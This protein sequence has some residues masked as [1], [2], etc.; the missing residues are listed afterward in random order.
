MASFVLVHGGL[1]GAWCWEPLT[2]ALRERGHAVHAMDLPCDDTTADLNDYVQA[3]LRAMAPLATPP[4]LV[5][6]SM[7]GLIIPHVARQAPVAALVYLCSMVAPSSPAD[8]AANLDLMSEEMKAGRR[9]DPLGRSIYDPAV[10]KSLFFNAV[11]PALQDWAVGRLRPQSQQAWR[12]PPYID[13]LPVAPAFAFVAEDDHTTH[14]P[15]AQR[16]MLRDRLGVEPIVLPGGHSPF[17][18]CPR[19]LADHFD[20]IAATLAADARGA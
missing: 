4:I 15:A 2:P 20:R 13:Q 6:H 18:G 10:A 14:S 12:S 16:R 1:H 5:G 3:V 9:S 19:I 17:L 7:A 8:H 11:P